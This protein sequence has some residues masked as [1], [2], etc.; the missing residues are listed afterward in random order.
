MGSTSVQQPTV[1]GAGSSDAV[2]AGGRSPSGA[3]L[4]AE[5]KRAL[6]ELARRTVDQYLRT[7]SVPAT[8]PADPALH[9][10]RGA[11]VTL[12]QN[13]ELR[14]CI[15]SLVGRRPLYLQVQNS[16]VMAATQ[17][18][19]FLPVTAAEVPSLEI[20]ISAL[21]PLEIVTDVSEIEVGTHGL[22]IEKG[23]RSGTLLPQVPGDYGWDRDQF[24]VQLCRKAGLPDDAWKSAKLYRYTAEVFHE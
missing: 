13:G 3:R 21:G 14:G 7:Q 15:G 22:L 4:T 18:P 11:F 23:N 12:T 10:V 17:D 20:E 16:A 19:R 1:Q 5:Q 2:G 24:L 8:A 6:L 9:Q